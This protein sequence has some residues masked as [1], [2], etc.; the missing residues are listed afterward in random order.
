MFIHLFFISEASLFHKLNRHS[1]Q[2]MMFSPWFPPLKHYFSA[3][4]G[5]Y[6]SEKWCSNVRISGWNITSKHKFDLKNPVN[7]DWHFISSKE[8]NNCYI[9]LLDFLHP[10]KTLDLSQVSFPLLFPLCYIVPSVFTNSDKWKY[11]GKNFW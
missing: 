7:S 10:L 5:I 8:L 6:F 4:G 9:L 2:K 3:Y 1:L 11:K